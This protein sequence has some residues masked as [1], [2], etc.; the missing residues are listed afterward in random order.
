MDKRF[1]W[2]ELCRIGAAIEKSELGLGSPFLVEW[3]SGDW[4]RRRKAQLTVVLLQ[5]AAF[6]WHS[7]SSQRAMNQLP[8]CL[9]C[10]W[11]KDNIRTNC[12]VPGA[13]NT[14]M[15][16]WF[17]DNEELVAK[18]CHRTQLGR[19]GEPEEVATS[20]TF[21]CLPSSFIIG[22]VITVDGGKTICGDY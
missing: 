20:V 1:G 15:A 11:A 4:Q 7:E 21:L 10:E 6:G 13:V 18:W 19:V 5:E 22:Q 8:R 17:M 12:V 2:S 9:A 14:P 3:N 16:K